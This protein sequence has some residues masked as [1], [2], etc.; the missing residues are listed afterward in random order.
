MKKTTYCTIYMSPIVVYIYT[1][2]RYTYSTPTSILQIDGYYIY[3]NIYQFILYRI[4]VYIS[5]F[6]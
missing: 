6:K 3:I 1:R 2:S 4:H 5:R